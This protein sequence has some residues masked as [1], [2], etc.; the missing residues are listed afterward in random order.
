MPKNKVPH[1]P[2]NEELETLLLHCVI[3]KR[4]HLSAGTKRVTQVWNEVNEMFFEQDLTEDLKS[5]HYQEGNVRKL[6][7]K[8]DKV[9][10]SV[11]ENIATGNQSGKEGELSLLFQHV[12]TIEEEIEEKDGKKEADGVL[13]VQLNNAEK[14]VLEGSG[15]LKRKKLNG[16]VVDIT[17]GSRKAPKNFVDQLLDIVKSVNEDDYKTTSLRS[18]EEFELNFKKWIDVRNLDLFDLF[19][20]GD[21]SSRFRSDVEE[22]GLKT[23][24]SIYCTAEDTKAMKA[25]LREMGLPMLVCSKVYMALQEWRRECIVDGGSTTTIESDDGTSSSGVSLS[26]SSSTVSSLSMSSVS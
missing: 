11:S 4:A 21:I 26:S 18:A 1:I 6:R 14:T 12:K 24:I 5:I 9:V 19:E 8:Y 22:I 16:E 23:L 25:E 13:K 10:E 7:E 2:W 3:V 17:Q 15:P 20:S